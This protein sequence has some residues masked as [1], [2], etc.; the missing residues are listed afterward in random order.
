MLNKFCF[1]L[2]VIVFLFQP[3]YSQD[4]RINYNDQY[5]FL[6]GANLAWFSFANDIG[7][8]D[9]NYD[10][11]ADVMLEMHDHG[12]NGLR[13]WLH[14]NGG[15]TPVFNAEDFVIGPG[16][17]TITDLK[18]ILDLAWE[19]E[20]GQKLCL[21]S[22]DML[23]QSNDAEVLDRNMLILTDST[24][25]QA[26]IDNALIPMVDS[27]KDHPG[28]IAWEIFNEPEGMSEEF[29]WANIN[30][31]PMADIQRFVNRC[32]GAIHRTDSSAQVTNGAW[33]FQA[34]SDISIGKQSNYQSELLSLS[35]EQKE[36]MELR[37]SLKYGISLTIEEI[38]DKNEKDKILANFNYYSDKRLI[39]VG[40]D[41][42]GTLDFYSVHYYDWG[43]TDLSPFHHSASTWG[44][45]KPIV[46]AEFNIQET[47]GIPED[48]LFPV[49]YGSGYAG[50]L[51]WSWTDNNFSTPEQ[52]L[53]AMQYMWDN[54]RESVDVDGIGGDWPL[55]SLTSPDSNSVFD[56]GAQIVLEAESSDN[57]GDVILV[58]FFASDIIKIGEDAESP[59]TFTWTNP[60]DGFYTITAVATDD[61]G[62]QRV[63]N[64]VQITVGTPDY[65]RHEAEAAIREGTPRVMEDP[66]ASS[67]NFVQFEQNGTITW[68]FSGV[69]NDSS[70][71]MIIGCRLS[72]DRPKNQYLNVNGERF[73]TIVFDSTLNTWFEKKINVVLVAGTNEIQ[74][75]MDWGYM[76]FDYIAL[77]EYFKN[78]TRIE[79]ENIIPEVFTLEQNFPNPFN[80]TTFIRY[81]LPHPEYVR[82]IVYNVTGQRIRTL[83]DKEQ[84]MGSYTTE[85]SAD[86]LASGVYFYHLEAGKYNQVKKMILLK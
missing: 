76:D 10:N 32:T 35:T 23:R 34:L 8:G 64:R 45:D 46:V 4:N 86:G 33:S 19:R 53:A 65:K 77:P 71:Q 79:K 3:V 29:G 9:T 37:F 70:Y 40:G 50:A 39:E 75:E 72:F 22:F 83:I 1:T 6:S 84:N 15:N 7:S 13:W 49:L 51:P 66:S 41:S 44:L 74:I 60:D 78:V 36:D 16:E 20:I 26:Y 52:M 67:G 17:S 27:L 58:E 73:S 48:Q 24:Y 69:P 68:K 82:L 31:V 62:H 38:A 11:F 57:D 14:A 43:G 25:M 28:I 81:T 56:K 55:V 2:F 21:W 30:H 54:H 18:N 85:F 59:Y 12:G 61:D 47:Y 80:P 5:L 42:L 63:S